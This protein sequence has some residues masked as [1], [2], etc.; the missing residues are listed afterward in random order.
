MRK[1][2]AIVVACFS[3]SGCFSE[4]P[5]PTAGTG[6]FAEYMPITDKQIQDLDERLQEAGQRGA[7]KFDAGAYAEAS[8]LLTRSRRELAAGLVLDANAD[9]ARLERE[10]EAIEARLGRTGAESS[11]DLS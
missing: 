6:G 10:V 3:L 9:I 5:W 1:L 8:T 11:R 7:T 2:V 4:G